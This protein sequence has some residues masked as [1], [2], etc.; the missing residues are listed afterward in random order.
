[1]CFER[2]VKILQIHIKLLSAKSLHN[3]Q[4]LIIVVVPAE[5]MFPPKY[6]AGLFNA[7]NGATGEWGLTID[8][9]IHPTLHISRL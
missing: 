1:V 4:Q 5:E 2:D 9:S 6:L 3:F 7:R 8:A